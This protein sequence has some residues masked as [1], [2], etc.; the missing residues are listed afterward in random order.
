MDQQDDLGNVSGVNKRLLQGKTSDDS[1]LFGH[2][3][4]ASSQQ[5]NENQSRTGSHQAAAQN[6]DN[7]Q[8]IGF[9]RRQLQVQSSEE[10]EDDDSENSDQGPKRWAETNSLEMDCVF[11][12]EEDPDGQK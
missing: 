9:D 1:G 3:S 7:L 6:G 8:D 12:E 4:V 5:L 2:L 11:L 10:D